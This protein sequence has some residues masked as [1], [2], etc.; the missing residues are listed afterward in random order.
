[1]HA[2]NDTRQSEGPRQVFA[3][4][5]ATLKDLLVDQVQRSKYRTSGGAAFLNP[6]VDVHY[7]GVWPDDFLYP[8]L[9][10]PELMSDAE[11]AELLQFLTGSIVDLDRLPDRVEPDGMPILSP[12][13]YDSPHTDRMP[14]HL[15][16]AWVRLLCYCESRGISI[17]RKTDWWRIVRRS[18]E[19][20]PF[21]CGLVYVDPQRPCVGYGFYDGVAITGWELMCSLIHCRGL[22]AASRLF[23]GVGEARVLERWTTMAQRIR[24]SLHRLFDPGVGG[25][26]AGSRDC[27]QFS[28][29]GNGLAYWLADE[30]QRAAIVEFYRANRQRIFVGGCARQIAEESGWQRM[31]TSSTLGEYMNGGAWPTGTGYV[32]PAIADRDPALACQVA[33]Q[34]VETVTEHQAPEWLDSSGA[35]RGAKQFNASIALPMLGLKSILTRT[36]LI[37]FF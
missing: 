31:L 7:H 28:V 29:W 20:V 34:L 15:P 26:V 22:A 30:P 12:G 18:Y 11:L 8:L 23:A 6:S 13:T 3:S 4:A 19:M 5:F 14:L 2:L 27:R 37:D 24:E 36:S 32:L 33:G 10:A 35:P 9:S 1:M 25:F 17:P 21:A 16:S